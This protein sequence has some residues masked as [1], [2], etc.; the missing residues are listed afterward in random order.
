MTEEV[1]GLP[2]AGYKKTQSQEAID[3]VN[4]GKLL[5]ERLLR[6]I[7]RVSALYPTDD[8]RRFLA[9]GRTQIQIGCM[10][11]FRAVFNPGRTPL[12]EDTPVHDY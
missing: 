6:Y 7:D 3:L 4:E 10:A 11:V 9:V 12:P 1:P 2:V 8:S 5:E